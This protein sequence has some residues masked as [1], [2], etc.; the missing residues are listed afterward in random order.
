MI[1]IKAIIVPL[2]ISY[3][4][5]SDFVDSTMFGNL[6]TADNPALHWTEAASRLIPCPVV[7]R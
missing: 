5:R 3:L 6:D 4:L 2:G 7:A 1:A